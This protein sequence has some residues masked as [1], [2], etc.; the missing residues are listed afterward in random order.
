MDLITFHAIMWSGN[1][2]DVGRG[3]RLFRRIM[4]FADGDLA[5]A[6]I[7]LI[8]PEGGITEGANRRIVEELRYFS[9]VA[10]FRAPGAVV[11]FDQ[12][13]FVVMGGEAFGDLG[14][15]RGDEVRR[16]KFGNVN[17]TV[18]AKTFRPGGWRSGALFGSFLDRAGAAVGGQTTQKGSAKASNLGS[19]GADIFTVYADGDGAK[20][21]QAEPG[22]FQNP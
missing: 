14:A 18:L 10:D 2:V 3:R 1:A 7:V 6:H 13:A 8:F 9:R 21:D 16:E 5:F 11:V 12:A 22:D 4:G 17:V 19:D 15:S 20:A